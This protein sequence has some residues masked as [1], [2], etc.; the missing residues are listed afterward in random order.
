MFTLFRVSVNLRFYL[1]ITA[2]G[3]LSLLIS[4]PAAPSGIE[5]PEAYPNPTADIPWNPGY[6]GV[7]D[8]KA[9]FNYGRTQE[10]SQLGTSIPLINSMPSQSTWDGMS[11]NAKALWLIDSERQARGINRLHGYESNITQVAQDYADFLLDNDEWGH[12]ADGS[13]AD[14]KRRNPVIRT[15]YDDLLLMENLHCFGT[16]SSSIPLPIERSVYNWMYKDKGSGWGHRKLLLYEGFNENGGPSDREGLMGIG[17]ASGGDYTI[18]GTVYPTSEIIVFNMF[19][20][21]SSWDYDAP[22]PSPGEYFLPLVCK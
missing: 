13:P 14:R 10:N 5:S 11:D 20:P 6:S 9:A 3:I 12:N 2:V 22:P 21:C 7:N 18:N 8:I 1:V 19:D 15:C 17:R 16:T 4:A